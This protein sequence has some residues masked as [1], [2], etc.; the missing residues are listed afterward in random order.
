ML[1][2]SD[3]RTQVGIDRWSGSDPQEQPDP[4]LTDKEK[5]GSDRKE[6]HY[7]TPKKNPKRIQQKNGSGPNDIILQNKNLTFVEEFWIRIQIFVFI[8]IRIK[9]FKGFVSASLL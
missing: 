3:L 5:T 4:D 2:K 6:K 9:A 7:S 1:L 8:R